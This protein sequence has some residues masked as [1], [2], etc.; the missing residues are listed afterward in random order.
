MQRA[1]Y[2]SRYIVD[3]MNLVN[4]KII[5]EES[6][7]K[8][9]DLL[10]DSILNINEVKY[11]QNKNVWKA[12]F[13]REFLEDPRLIKI[14][15]KFLW[16]KKYTFPFCESILTLNNIKEYKYIDKAKINGYYFN[17]CKKDKKTNKFIFYF[18]EDLFMYFEFFN[19]PEGSLKDIKI[20]NDYSSIW[21][22]GNWH[23]AST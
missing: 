5:D 11:D 8:A 10:H 19:L 21:Y 13:K 16:Y 2:T 3:K 23:M 4:I 20:L 6:I 1:A 7:I 14:E 22:P 15:R 9:C 18:C 12:K 17:G